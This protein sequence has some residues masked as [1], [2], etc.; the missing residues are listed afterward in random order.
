MAVMAL[1]LVDNISFFRLATVVLIGRV[2]L[3]V[4]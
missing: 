1:G 2:N 3:L 4:H